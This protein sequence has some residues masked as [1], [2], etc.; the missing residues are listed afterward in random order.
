MMTMV[1]TM[2]AIMEVTMA[3]VR[4]T[5]IA[6]MLAMALVTVP[7]MAHIWLVVMVMTMHVSLCADGDSDD[8]TDEG[9]DVLVR[10]IGPSF[11]EGKGYLT[12][13]LRCPDCANQFPLKLSARSATAKTATAKMATAMA[14]AT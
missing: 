10:S 6:M 7:P 3:E 8:D 4:L 13:L 12:P 5:T 9:G 2:W 14:T 1:M 11:L